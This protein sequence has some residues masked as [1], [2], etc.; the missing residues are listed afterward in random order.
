MVYKK[1]VM[2]LAKPSHPVLQLRNNSSYISSHIKK[3]SLKNLFWDIYFPQR[4]G[5]ESTN[6][7]LS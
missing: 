6:D 5:Y 7:D 2:G 3:M 1:A 4:T